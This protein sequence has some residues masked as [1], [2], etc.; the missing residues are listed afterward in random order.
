MHNG[1]YSL[2]EG[3]QLQKISSLQ[4]NNGPSSPA[5]LLYLS[6]LSKSTSLIIIFFEEWQKSECQQRVK[7]RIWI[8]GNHW[9][10]MH[11][12][13]PVRKWSKCAAPMERLMEN[14]LFI[15][16]MLQSKETMWSL[17]LMIQ[18]SSSYLWLCN[19][20]DPSLFSTCCLAAVQGRVSP[21]NAQ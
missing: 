20:K 7:G 3:H 5:I 16:H 12:P 14:S 15:P 18:I 11:S 1:Q 13:K 10:E 2:Q 17:H 21:R 9:W 6:C 19:Q 4:S 8:P